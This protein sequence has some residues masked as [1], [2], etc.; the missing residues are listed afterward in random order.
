MTFQRSLEEEYLLQ[1]IENA[2]NCFSC[3][4]P[5]EDEYIVC[6]HCHTRLQEGCANCGR[7]FDVRWSVCPYCAHE[8]G[9]PLAVIR[10]VIQPL[11]RYVQPQPRMLIGE[12][13]VSR[14]IEQLEAQAFHRLDTVPQPA[15]VAATSGRAFDRRKTREMNRLRMSNGYAGGH[16]ENGPSFAG[17]SAGTNDESVV[18]D[19][20][21]PESA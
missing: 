3:D 11:E 1:D 14:A 19:A 2:S 5:I 21:E 17:A 6:P 7:T 9:A 4:R 15:A 12:V 13:P 16:S 8:K 10:P 18:S 20:G